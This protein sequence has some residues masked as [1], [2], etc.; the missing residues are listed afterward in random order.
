M[1]P[2]SVEIHTI[3]LLTLGGLFLL[4]LVADLVGRLTPLPRV[5]LLLLTGL[6]IGPSGFPYYLKFS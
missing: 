6:L 4:G 5:S 2:E 1:T 3:I